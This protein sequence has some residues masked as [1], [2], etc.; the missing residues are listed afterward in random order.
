MTGCYIPI[1]IVC[2]D[3]NKAPHIGENGNWWIGDED[4]GIKAQGQDGTTPHIGE[5][6]NWFLGDEDTGVKA[7]GADGEVYSTEATRIGTWY[8]GKPLYRRIFTYNGII[9]AFVPS[10]N[11]DVAVTAVPESELGNFSQIVK[12]YGHA[13]TT[14]N[15]VV[16]PFPHLALSAVYKPGDGIR[17]IS[18]KDGKFKDVVIIMEYTV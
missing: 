17:M 11:V 13:T 12:L 2:D 10:S 16:T 5:N 3:C 6:G 15:L 8:D 4:T 1:P 18:R 9:P 7:Q 14:I